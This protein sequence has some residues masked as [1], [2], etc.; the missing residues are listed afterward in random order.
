MSATRSRPDMLP[1]GTLMLAAALV[2]FAFAATVT[3]RVAGLPVAASPAALRAES[4]VQAV[5][6]RSL[7]FVDRADGA[8]VIQDAGAGGV[9]SV[10][11]PGEQTGFVRGVMRGLAR[12]RRQHGIGDRPPFTLTLWRDGQLSLT[13]SA[14][15][16]SVELTAFGSSNRAAFAALLPG[17]KGSTRS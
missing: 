6:S 4:R 11:E 3:V 9:A 10:I 7:R 14:T 2:T 8:V 16:R 12:E 5:A 17:A 15:G 1:R 13:D